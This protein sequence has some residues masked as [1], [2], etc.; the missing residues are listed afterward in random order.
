M[1]ACDKGSVRTLYTG[2]KA[3]EICAK[4]H[5]LGEDK[6]Q[7]VFDKEISGAD[8]IRKYKQLLDE[9]II[10]QEEFNR[11]KKQILEF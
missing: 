7:I 11:K 3:E 4:Y 9:G 5:E 2:I 10:S 6:Q 8:E 1:R